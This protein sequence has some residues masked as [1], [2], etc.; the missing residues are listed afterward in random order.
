MKY[1]NIF[2]G[3][4]LILLGT[5]YLLKQFDVIY[6][7]WRDIVRL[8]PLLLVL[9]GISI[10]PIKSLYKLIASFVAILVMI[11]II[12]YNP[13]RWHSGWI[14]IGDHDRGDRI[15]LKRSEPRSENGEYATLELDAAAGTYVIEGISDQLVDFKYIGDSG[16]YFMS[17]T[18]E[19]EMQRVHIGPEHR[20]NQYRLYRSHE[21]EIKMNP[22]MAWDIDV[23]AG[24]ADIWM[25]LS[26]FIIGELTIDGGA[27]SI[28]IKL[29]S[30]S[31]NLYVDIETG[32]S[33]VKIFVP[34]EVACEVNSDSFLVSR[35]L[36]GFDKVSKSTYVS[37]NFA[38][39]SKNISIQFSSGI[40][41]LRVVRY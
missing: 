5:L 3:V 26:P 13:S 31:D 24:A 9:W 23:D 18:D 21:V 34:E 8:W 4:L 19:G 30:L 29:G 25:D 14:W 32:V 2:W 15:E 28:E 17:T 35:E 33:S 11:L 39:A 22:D 38:D 10:L 7:N 12:H 16:S 6:F 20:R 40:S 27:T 1:K 41:S 36:P 37:P